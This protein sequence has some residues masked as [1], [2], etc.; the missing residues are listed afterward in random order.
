M[1]FRTN[2]IFIVA[3]FI[4]SFPHVAM[5]DVLALKT[6]KELTVENAWWEGDQICFI[7]HGINACIPQSKLSNTESLSKNRYKGSASEKEKKANLEKINKDPAKDVRPAQ[8]KQKAQISPVLQQTIIPTEQAC[9]LQKDGFCDLKW[10]VEVSK[11]DGLEKKQTD[12]GMVDVIEY[13]RPKYLLKIGDV[14]LA[15]TTYSFWRDRLFTVTIW[16]EDYPN[17]TAL[18]EKVFQKYGKGRQADQSRERYLW[19]DNP[20]DMMLQYNR[21]SRH[22]MLWLRCSEMNRKYKLSQM[23]GPR[24]LLKWMN[25]RN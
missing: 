16:T 13:T 18:R 8:T 22:G 21:D 7:Y 23:N 4:I 3:L 14:T 20:T 25:S 1:N 2:L 12:S 6:G 9:V 10:G 24:H 15:S 11:V 17:Y 19:L 5:A